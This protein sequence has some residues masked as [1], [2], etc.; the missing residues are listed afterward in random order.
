MKKTN[1][2]SKISYSTNISNETTFLPSLNPVKVNGFSDITSKSIV[3]FG[4]N[5]TSTLGIS[6]TL[7]QLS[8]VNL[9]PYQRSVIIGL[10]LSDG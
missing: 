5:L 6:F 4:S 1:F 2:L 9:A 7:N 10:L 3:V 8:M